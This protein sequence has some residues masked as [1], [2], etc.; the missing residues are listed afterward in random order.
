MNFIIL[1]L[2]LDKKKC[3]TSFS[4]EDVVGSLQINQYYVQFISA[5]YNTI[6]RIKEP[7]CCFAHVPIQ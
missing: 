5:A 1:F 2:E 3:Q 4:E 6:D 7:D